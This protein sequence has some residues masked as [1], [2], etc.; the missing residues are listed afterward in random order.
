MR[1]SKKFNDDDLCILKE[2]VLNKSLKYKNIHAKP[3]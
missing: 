3:V 1:M 2:A